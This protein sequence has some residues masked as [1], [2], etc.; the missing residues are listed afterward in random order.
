MLMEFAYTGF[1]EIQIFF[2]K[3]YFA[4][5]GRLLLDMF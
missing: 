3:Y 4:K 2:E 5:L 1:V